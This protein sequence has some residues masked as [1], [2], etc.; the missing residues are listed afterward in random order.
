M[1]VLLASIA[2][3]GALTMAAP[4][5][6][7]E[8]RYGSG[9]SVSFNRYDGQSYAQRSDRQLD[10]LANHIHQGRREGAL[11]RAEHRSLFRDLIETQQLRRQYLRT[12]G[13]SRWEARDLQERIADLRRDLRRS[14]FDNDRRFTSLRVA[15]DNDDMFRGNE[16]FDGR[17][18]DDSRGDGRNERGDGRRD[19]DRGPRGDR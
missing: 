19:N 1:K 9:Y 12:R 6:A 5:N 7:Q 10:R 14:M 11:T 4:A 15:F 2:A 8:G 13:L 3:L 17:F 18:D 16:R